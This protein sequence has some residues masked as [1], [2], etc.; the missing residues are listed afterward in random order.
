MGL[1]EVRG[2]MTMHV[3]GSV[4]ENEDYKMLWDF[5]V[6]TDHE[7]EARKPDLLI[8]DKSENNCKIIDVAIPEDGRVRAKED[9]KVEKYQDLAREV[10]Q[11]WGVRTKVIPM[12]V[13]TLGSMPLRLKENL[14]TRGID[15]SIELIQRSVLLG[16]A[17]ILRKVLEM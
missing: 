11:I 16:S 15:T 17:R 10:R 9:E 3:P 7:I 12:V 1:S 8:I 6:R 13:G 14:R 4:L 2:G 5:S